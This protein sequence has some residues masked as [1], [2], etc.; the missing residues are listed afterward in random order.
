MYMYYG[1]V[2][3]VNELRVNKIITR[4]QTNI[5]FIGCKFK[6]VIQGTVSHLHRIK[7]KDSKSTW[8]P[9]CKAEVILV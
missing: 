2:T 6:V 3:L 9:G 7:Q 4:V 8:L 5:Q 1:S